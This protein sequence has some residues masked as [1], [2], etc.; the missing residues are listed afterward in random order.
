MR[1]GRWWWHGEGRHR[2]VFTRPRVAL[3]VMVVLLIVGSNLHPLESVSYAAQDGPD[4]T[5]LTSV[6][7][8]DIISGGGLLVYTPLNGK[9]NQHYA[10]ELEIKNIIPLNE[11]YAFLHLTRHQ[12]LLSFS[13]K[14]LPEGGECATQA[15]VS[16]E[17]RN[18]HRSNRAGINHTADLWCPE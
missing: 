8:A 18:G 11:S 15:Y 6:L 9:K 10:A 12:N 1:Q 17:V 13:M 16:T 7:W 2:S 14:L 5:Q 3:L 4:K